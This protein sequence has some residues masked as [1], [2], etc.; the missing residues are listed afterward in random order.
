MFAVQPNPDG[1]KLSMVTLSASPGSAPSIWMGPVT[2]FTLE[3][4]RLD[5]AATVLSGVK[6]PPPL[7]R[8]SKYTVE[9]GTTCSAA[10][11][12]RSQP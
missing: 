4:S 12:E 8:H 6:W 9:P 10:G 1:V 5:T 11:I 2:G 3:K 7:S